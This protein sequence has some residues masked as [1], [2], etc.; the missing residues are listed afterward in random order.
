MGD[1]GFTA[2]PQLHITKLRFLI[3]FHNRISIFNNILI[4]LYE[5]VDRFIRI[6]RSESV[7]IKLKAF[8]V[9]ED[10]GKYFGG[11]GDKA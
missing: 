1:C 6:Y 10:M 3:L 7:D 5:V 9:E 8:A 2:Y 11:F 4:R